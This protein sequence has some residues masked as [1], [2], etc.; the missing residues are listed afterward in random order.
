VKTIARILKVSAIVLGVL[1]LMIVIGMLQNNTMII[2]PGA[3]I[4]SNDVTITNTTISARIV[5][6][7]HDT[8][9]SQPATVIL[10]MDTKFIE[11]DGNTVKISVKDGLSKSA[12]FKALCRLGIH[13]DA[14]SLQEARVYAAK[15]VLNYSTVNFA[16]AMAFL[17]DNGLK[18]EDILDK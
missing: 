5:N 15:E 11:L 10:T 9:C 7:K 6:G 8:S 14:E 12:G 13:R 4:S 1:G 17:A 16:E 2:M 18:P 3:T